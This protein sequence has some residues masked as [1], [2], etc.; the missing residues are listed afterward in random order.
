MGN[1]ENENPQMQSAQSGWAGYGPDLQE[2]RRRCNRVGIALIACM[3]AVNLVGFGLTY[4]LPVS[5]LDSDLVLL[6][7][8]DFSYYVVG[9]L[10]LWLI[11][12]PL[13]TQTPKGDVIPFPRFIKW[14][15]EDIGLTY[16]VAFLTMFLIWLIFEKLLGLTLT[17]SVDSLSTMSLPILIVFSVIVAPI[18]EEFLFRKLLL[19]RLLPMGEGFAIVVSSVAFGLFHQNLYQL[20]FAAAAGMLYAVM[21]VKTGDVR[22]PMIMHAITNVLSVVSNVIDADSDAATWYVLAL[23]FLMVIGLGYVTRDIRDIRSG[24]WAITTSP[25]VPGNWHAALTS[26]GMITCVVILVVLSLV[27]GL[28]G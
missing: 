28:F 5:L 13:P 16:S 14:F 20:F 9:G 15:F 23:L 6:L 4:A 12:R 11:L 19:E 2:I 24:K 1:W 7:V 17:N 21:A 8:N 25:A 26:P 27:M 3:A 10:V 18:C 22:C